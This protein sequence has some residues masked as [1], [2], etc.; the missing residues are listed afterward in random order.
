[1]KP[2]TGFEINCYVDADFGGLF[3]ADPD[4][5]PTSARSCTGYIIQLNWHWFWS[6]VRDTPE[7]GSVLLK[8]PRIS[9]LQTTGLSRETFEKIRVLSQGW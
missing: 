5:E 1:M 2:T 7:K 4:S 6:H 9:R 8:L 3:R